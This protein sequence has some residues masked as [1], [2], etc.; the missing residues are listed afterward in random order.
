MKKFV[1]L[2]IVVALFIGIPFC[3]FA[4]EEPRGAS[5]SCKRY[6]AAYPDNFAAYY[7]N[8]GECVG[9]MQACLTPRD[10]PASCLCRWIRMVYPQAYEAQFG[11]QSL[12]PCIAD[13]RDM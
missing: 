11:T 3:V 10:E 9:Y 12:A 6:A 13:L 4:Q 1:V 5:A 7:K 8:L 2:T